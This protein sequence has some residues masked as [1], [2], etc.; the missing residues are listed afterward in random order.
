MA[1]MQP[2]VGDPNASSAPKGLNIRGLLITMVI[3]GAIPYILFLLL[4]PHF[5]N[6]SVWPLLLASVAPAIGNA[7]SI[8]RQRRLDYL[9][10]IVIL[11]LIFTIVASV[12]SGAKRQ[13]SQALDVLH[14][15]MERS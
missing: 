11:S 13:E 4:T 6:G 10:V 1:P 8:V 14:R 7:I 15:K 3:D 2:S 5:P 9:G 12:V